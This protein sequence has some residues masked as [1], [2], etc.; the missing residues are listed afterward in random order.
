MTA[1]APCG[2]AAVNTVLLT[3]V[4]MCCLDSSLTASGSCGKMWHRGTCN[5][6]GCWHAIGRRGFQL[7]SHGSRNRG[8]QLTTYEPLVER[9]C[10]SASSKAVMK[11]LKQT[12]SSSV[13]IWAGSSDLSCCT[14]CKAID[15]S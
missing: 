2:H 12:F 9:C 7:Q 1:A 14:A 15:A 6:Q 13:V 11:V 5:S 4:M 8:W 3:L 10:Q